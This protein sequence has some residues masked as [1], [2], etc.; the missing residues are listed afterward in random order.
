VVRDGTTVV[1][2]PAGAPPQ[3]VSAPTL[4]GLGVATALELSPDGVRAAVVLEGPEG[5]A[6]YV[7]TVVRAEDGS[8]ALRDLRDVAPS[9]SQVA[10]VAWRDSD[11]LLVLAGDAGED[12]IVPY[13]VDV[14]GWGLTAVPTAGLPSQPTSIGAAPTRQPLVDAGN[15]IW[16]LAGGTWVTLVR[17]REPLPG[18]APFYP[19]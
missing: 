6:L 16:Q 14:D 1:R 3:P 10:D 15:T 12:R 8:V 9:L 2:V 17:G 7:G 13:D 19:L 18:N 5:P 11:T 4:P